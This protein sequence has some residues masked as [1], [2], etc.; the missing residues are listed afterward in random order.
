MLDWEPPFTAHAILVDGEH[1]V[2]WDRKHF[3]FKGSCQYVLARDELDGNFTVSVTLENGKFKSVKVTDPKSSIE[4][5]N[6]ETLKLDGQ[7]AEYP[8]HQGDLHAWKK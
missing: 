2:T 7:P 8:V 6:D 1:F 5:A 3:T 4:M